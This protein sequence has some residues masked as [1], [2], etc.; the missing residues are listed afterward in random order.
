[1]DRRPLEGVRVLDLTIAMAGPLCTQRLGEMGAEVV[2]IEAPG[3]GD[4]SRHAPMAGV[5]RF[6]DAMCFTE[7]NQNKRGLVLDLKSEAGRSVL[8]R[9]A[10]RAD[11]LVQNFRPR[12]AAKLGLDWG[13]LH[14]LNPRLVYGAISGYGAEGPMAD[15]PGQ[16]LL[17]QAYTGLAMNGGRRGDLPAASPLY[18]VDVSASHMLCEGV[19]AA[20]VARG[21]SGEGQ[22]VDVSMV[23]AILE[24]Q[25]QEVATWLAA[26]TPPERGESPQVS[27]YQEPPY[28]LYVCAEGFLAI[29]QAKLPVLAEVLELPRLAELAAARPEDADAAAMTAWR[30]AVWRA[31]SDRLAT[32]PASHWDGL[33]D[34][35]GL[36]CMVVRDYAAFLGDPANA[37]HLTEIDHPVGGRYRSVAP[38]ISFPDAPPPRLRHA[39]LY[40]AEGREVLA[41]WGFGAEEVARLTDA[42]AVVTA[43]GRDAA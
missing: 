5:T 17:V 40:A 4:F 10:E 32:A 11:V 42:G 6:G 43:E 41:D 38:G 39:P 27:I 1:M 2:K 18:M 30:D 24:M 36:W 29:A 26:E 14:A 23:G 3:G 21:T 35:A 12:V 15:R 7:L 28:G 25:C 9:M 34:A 31:L 16:D 33:L 8:H 19:L 13:T 37:R 20:L 22:R